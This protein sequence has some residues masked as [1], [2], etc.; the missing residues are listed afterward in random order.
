M[1]GYASLFI[2][3]ICFTLGESEIQKT[4]WCQVQLILILVVSEKDGSQKFMSPNEEGRHWLCIIN[5]TI[6]FHPN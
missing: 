4:A 6:I 2:N 3:N 5:H 1:F